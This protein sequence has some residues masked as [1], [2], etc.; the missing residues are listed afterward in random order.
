MVAPK[1]RVSARTLWELKSDKVYFYGQHPNSIR[2]TGPGCVMDIFNALAAFQN[3]MTCCACALEGGGGICGIPMGH[4]TRCVSTRKFE[5]D[6]I[7]WC[8]NSCWWGWST[9]QFRS[10]KGV[11]AGEW[12][13]MTNQSAGRAR[14]IELNF[15]LLVGCCPK[16]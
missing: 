11:A 14:L 6:T 2:C 16:Q 8:S 5:F 9:K 12:C 1:G 3:W 10:V 4:E 15:Y 13:A 7:I